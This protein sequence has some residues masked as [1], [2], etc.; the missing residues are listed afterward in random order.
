MNG[1]FQIFTVYNDYNRAGGV[2]RNKLRA[3]RITHK[4]MNVMKTTFLMCSSISKN[5]YSMQI[6]GNNERNTSAILIN[7]WEMRLTILT[8]TLNLIGHF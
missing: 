4:I 8:R 1:S 5:M 7:E 6:N 2:K 3:L